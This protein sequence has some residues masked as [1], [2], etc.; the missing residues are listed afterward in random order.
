M[1][2]TFPP[3]PKL[4]HI[5]HNPQPSP[6]RRHRNLVLPIKPLL[7]L[8]HPAL[9]PL[10]PI[11]PLPHRL[12]HLT[13]P[14]RPGPDPR[15]PRPR[16]KIPLTLLVTQPLHFSL[17]THL[18]LERLPPKHQARVGVASFASRSE[19][20]GG[21]ARRGPVRVHDEAAVAVEFFEVDHA[22][23]DA[24]GGEGG[25]GERAGFGDG[26]GKEWM[27]EPAVELDEWGGG[28]IR[29]RE[30]ADLELGGAGGVGG[31][32]GGAGGED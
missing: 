28:E 32:G 7:H 10:P 25:R 5:R 30:G 19:D 26:G 14:T 24:A 12:Q 11:I 29:E 27:A 1:Q 9:Q 18:P 2:A 6:K 8:P 17:D 21:F 16:V 4:H 31:V 23:G 13:L 20:V 3:L 15:A 22:G